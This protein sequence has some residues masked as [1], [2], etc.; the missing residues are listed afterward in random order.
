M[1]KKLDEHIKMMR[2]MS[3]KHGLKYFNLFGQLMLEQNM[4]I[5][6]AIYYC[7]NELM[8]QNK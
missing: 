5:E 1:S 2:E 4:D 7:W 3:D 6:T 8:T